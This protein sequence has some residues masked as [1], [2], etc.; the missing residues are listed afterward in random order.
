MHLV[1]SAEINALPG[2][3][4]SQNLLEL[5]LALLYLYDCMAESVAPCL[6]FRGRCCPTDSWDPLDHCGSKLIM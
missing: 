5:L 2:A 1:F 4:R 3:E 6:G